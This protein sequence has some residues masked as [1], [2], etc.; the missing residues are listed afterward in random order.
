MAA[1]CF[2]QL[3]LLHKDW[4]GA[5]LIAP[6][7]FYPIRDILN[8]GKVKFGL[9]KQFLVIPSEDIFTITGRNYSDIL[10]RNSKSRED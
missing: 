6:F 2:L 7:Y 3:L 4:I 9:I 1:T 10:K 5:G 8:T